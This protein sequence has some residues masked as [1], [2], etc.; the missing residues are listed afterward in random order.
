MTWTPPLGNAANLVESPAA[1]APPAGSA[2][3]LVEGFAGEEFARLRIT[4]TVTDST[5]V[6]LPLQVLVGPMVVLPL[7]VSVVDSS[8]PLE[9]P[10]RVTVSTPGTVTLGLALEV[11]DADAVGGLDG[12]GGWAAAPDGQWRA[13]V[14]LDGA[15]V[16]A[17]IV[18]QITVTHA[19]DAAAV[20][21]LAYLPAVAVQPLS[22][23]GRPVR[24]AFARADG[25]S[26][27]AMF[28]GVVDVPQ[29]D[30]ATGV[31]TLRC[32]DQ[33]QEVWSRTPRETIA[34][35]VGGRYSA[36]VVGNEPEDSYA[37]LQERIQSVGASWAIDVLGRVRVTPWG[38]TERAI[39][40]RTA[41][42][43]DGSLSVDL[44]SREQIRT[45][46]TCRLQYQY[47]RL[48]YRGVRAQYSQDIH[49]FKPFIGATVNY[50]GVQFLTTGMVKSACDSVP[51]FELVGEPEIEHP[52]ARSWQIGV[53]IMSGVFTIAPNV[54]PDLAL[55]FS[56]TFA[57]RWQQSL[58]EDWTVDVV[59][60]AMEA[61][62]GA[63][64]GEEIGASLV[65]EFDQPGWDSDAS[66]LP[67]IPDAFGVGDAV[68]P[69]QP[70]GFDATARDDAL[71][72]L[73]DRAWVRLWS[74][75]RS[76]RVSFDLPL[77]PDLWLDTR[78]TLEHARLRAAGKVAEV[79]HT[80][81]TASGAAISSVSLAV[82]MPGATP[83][84]LPAWTLPTA[85]ADDYNPPLSAFSFEI[86]TFVG[87]K[88]D[89]A[90][91]DE[92]TMIG[93]STNLNSV[94]EAGREYYPHQLSMRAPDIAAEDRDPR[95]LTTS[96]QIDVTVP[97]DLLEILA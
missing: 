92:S 12:A 6:A 66:I 46:I 22:L 24:I 17:R 39:T 36:A 65:A 4:V 2:V 7:A 81:D 89:S 77:R 8:A 52:P 64:V 86:G 53:S 41:D 27:Q 31:I 79:T 80:M 76:G 55:G 45:R 60:P 54:A 90:P 59:W 38:T 21:E 61:Q 3:N 78:V 88:P 44:P 85:P 5:V 56:A 91:F 94:T 18:G 43:L 58:T 37:Y 96:A 49:F 30:L 51:G 70:V 73:L 69:W 1:W 26:R 16:S 13:V 14:V 33:A 9:L 83:A 48:R 57:T 63:A 47:Q 95:T 32:H 72:A 87:G 82:G 19:D 34:A 67:S 71:R 62:L 68:L 28:T 75:S 97:T 35:L 11:I 74:A 20:A 23:I 84:T 15:D 50:P 25:S 29:I 40:V 93:F 42:V 10:L